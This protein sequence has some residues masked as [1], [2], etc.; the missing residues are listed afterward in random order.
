M[1]RAAA[2]LIASLAAPAY[3][4]AELHLSAT[5]TVAIQPDQL[6]ADLTALGSGASAASAQRQVNQLIAS[7]QALA[8][9]ATDVTASAQDY[10]VTYA[11]GTRRWTAQQT[12]ELRG[13]DGAATLALTGQ[14]QALGLAIGSLGW[15]ASDALLDQ[16]QQDAAIRALF[17]LRENATAD[18]RAL[19]LAVDHFKSVD[20]SGGPVAQ[21]MMGMR[22]AA[23]AVPAPQS[24]RQAQ[25]VSAT[26]SAD[27]VLKPK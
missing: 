11:E 20:V 24:T 14:L 10:S 12:L 17:K 2:L 19:D 3:A 25:N 1:R 5:A 4:Q 23:M 8:S 6:V 13:A 16:A 7:A 21:P 18:A 26:V 22:F 27:V 15:Q 9:K